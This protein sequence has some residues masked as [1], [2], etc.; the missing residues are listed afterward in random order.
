MVSTLSTPYAE[1]L[2]NL[3]EIFVLS[4][5][6]SGTS[7]LRVSEDKIVHVNFNRSRVLFQRATEIP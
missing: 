3:R 4:A 5:W 2:A 1:A 7:E 6:R